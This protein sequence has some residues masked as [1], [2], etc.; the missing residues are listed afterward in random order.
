MSDN[1]DVTT[2]FSALADKARELFEQL[3][4]DETELLASVTTAAVEQI[5]G[6]DWAGI[7]LVTKRGITTV[8]PTDEVSARIDQLQEAVGGP[9]VRAATAWNDHIVRVDD[10]RSEARW[11]EYISAA[12]AETPVRSTVAFQLYRS[13]ATMGALSVHSSQ[14]DAFTQ[15]AEEVGLAVATHGALALYAARREEQ[16][17]S[18]LASRDIIGQAKG[19]IMERFDIDALQAWELMRRLSQDSNVAVFQLAQQLIDADHPMPAMRSES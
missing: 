9:G 10:Y 18:A 1:N 7:T 15:E 14:P 5:P 3:P 19:M 8:A 4:A 17:A 12:L 11:P 2:R 13:D 6:A 16:F